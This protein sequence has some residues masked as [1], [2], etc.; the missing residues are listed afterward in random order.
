MTVND[1]MPSF[2]L[3]RRLRHV[4]SIR[5]DN[6]FARTENELD[7]DVTP[8]EASFLA[9][10]TLKGEHL[11][12]SEV[13]CGF[14]HNIQFNELPPLENPTSHI[15]LKIAVKLPETSSL[16][17]YVDRD[18]W[19]VLKIFEI[20]LNK[21]QGVNSDDLIDS[22]N[23]P[24][25]EMIDGFYT[26]PGLKTLKTSS[27]QSEPLAHKR[28]VSNTRLTQSFSYNSVLKLNKLIE[29]KTQ[30]LLECSSAA[31]EI[32]QAIPSGDKRN[33][34]LIHC[35]EKDRDELEHS[36]QKKEKIISGLEGKN[37]S[38]LSITFNTMAS[39]GQ[40]LNEYYGNTYPNVIQSKD[41]LDSM[42]LKR[43]CKLIAIFKST[44][45]FREE[46][47]LIS[48]TDTASETLYERT[49]L[50]LINK[51]RMMALA[52]VT[53]AAREM[54]NTCLGYYLMFIELVARKIYDIPLPYCMK[55]Y[56]SNSLIDGTHALFLNDSTSKSP[57]SFMEAIEYFNRNLVQV[58]Q[59]WEHRRSP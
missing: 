28:N 6:V 36:I 10:E 9:I 37:K 7:A 11:Y 23:A 40:S 29:Y 32:E 27:F 57:E 53:D 47:G 41:R 44:C 14:M 15:I 52:S 33:R 30:V 56:G 54:V 35:I 51:E 31:L 39:E 17:S 49:T 5:I 59:R 22:Y 19:L 2:L 16:S 1:H 12:V 58:I 25:F 21:L 3:K 43:L 38:K 20:D 45:L 48:V 46:M 4:R 8:F 50:K 18:S 34:W 42:R 13:Q 26:L 24:L 55:Y